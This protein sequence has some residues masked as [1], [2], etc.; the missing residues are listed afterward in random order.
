MRVLQRQPVRLPRRMTGTA[1][2]RTTGNDG[3]HCAAPPPALDSFNTA[4][5][6]AN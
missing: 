5:G 4:R 1:R 2:T 3:E 6:P